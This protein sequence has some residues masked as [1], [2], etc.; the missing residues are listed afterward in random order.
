MSKAENGYK[1][2]GTKALLAYTM[3]KIFCTSQVENFP[4]TMLSRMF[5]VTRLGQS[6]YQLCFSRNKPKG[7]DGIDKILG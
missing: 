1:W 4:D 7:A 3:E 5:G 2:N 6:R